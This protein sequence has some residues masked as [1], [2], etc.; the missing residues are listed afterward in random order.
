MSEAGIVGVHP[1]HGSDTLR[2]YGKGRGRRDAPSGGG[3]SLAGV[4]RG[5]RLEWR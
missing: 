5:S 1:R 2:A 4:S 3:E